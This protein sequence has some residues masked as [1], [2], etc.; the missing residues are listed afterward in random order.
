MAISSKNGR[1]TLTL[2]AK[3]NAA[4]YVAGTFNDWRADQT[5][6]TDVNS[7]GNYSCTLELPPGT[8]EYKF[9]VDDEWTIDPDNSAYVQNDLGTLNSVMVIR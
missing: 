3:R 1:V 6:L 8:Y 2:N 5:P 7:N 4:V 9:K